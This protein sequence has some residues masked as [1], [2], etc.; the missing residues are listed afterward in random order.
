MAIRTYDTSPREALADILAGDLIGRD[1][2]QVGPHVIRCSV[3]GVVRVN[4][5]PLGRWSDGAEALAAAF[6]REVTR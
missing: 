6:E 2:I 5:V 3:A 1:A 4:G